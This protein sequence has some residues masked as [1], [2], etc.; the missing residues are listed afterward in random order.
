MLPSISVAA[1]V[2]NTR[3]ELSCASLH[4]FLILP[5]PSLSPLRMSLVTASLVSI[6][7]ALNFRNSGPVTQ[8]GTTAK[9][10]RKQIPTHERGE[11]GEF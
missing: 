5:E 2:E 1:F 4:L 3:S 8:G 10:I 9:M 6:T 11:E 7:V